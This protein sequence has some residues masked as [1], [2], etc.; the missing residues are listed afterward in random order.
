MTKQKLTRING[1]TCRAWVQER[2]P[3]QNSNGQLFGQ[4]EN[5]DGRENTSALYVVYSYGQ[6]WPLFAY[7]NDRGLWFE[8]SDKFSRTTSKHRMQAHPLCDTLKLNCQR[9][10]ELVRKGYVATT[11]RRLTNG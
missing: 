4:W 1:R 5:L 8:N 9:M 7:D 3:F 10:I 11:V 6:H 2:T